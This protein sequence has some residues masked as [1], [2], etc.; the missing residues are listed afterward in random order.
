[1]LFVCLVFYSLPALS[2]YRGV[3]SQSK[4][5][6]LWGG[7]QILCRQAVPPPVGCL[8]NT[9]EDPSVPH[10]RKYI[11]PPQHRNGVL[12]FQTDQEKS[13]KQRKVECRPIM[14][15]SIL[16]RAA[17]LFHKSI[18]ISIQRFFITCLPTTLCIWSCD[19]FL[20]TILW[21][22]EEKKIYHFVSNF[23]EDRHTRSWPPTSLIIDTSMDQ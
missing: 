23:F 7:V 3:Y 2:C 15:F 16:V 20:K 11:T 21:L 19:N 5:V 17:L 1:M 10:M 9:D 14:I 13:W 6:E 12:R 22:K 4:P 8:G 18:H